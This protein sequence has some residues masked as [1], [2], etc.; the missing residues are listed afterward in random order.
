MG[1]KPHQAHLPDE[2]SGLKKVQ[3][4]YMG[5]VLLGSYYTWAYASFRTGIAIGGKLRST[6]PTCMGFHAE[7]RFRSLVQQIVP[8]A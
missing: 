7:E 6:T 3:L 4:R 2:H 1:E 8:P 5:W